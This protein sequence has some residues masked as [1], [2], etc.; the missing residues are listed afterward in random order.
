LA[1]ERQR[2]IE[3]VRRALRLSPGDPL[4]GNWFNLLAMA[5][6]RAGQYAN[7]VEYALVATSETP[8]FAVAHAWLAA[9][10]V[11]LGG[12]EKAKAALESARRIAPK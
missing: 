7:G 9:N 8:G 6:C 12:I 11:D 1:G 2:A 3:I 5:S 4:R 10:Y